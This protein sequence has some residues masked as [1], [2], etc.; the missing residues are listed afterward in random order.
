MLDILNRITQGEGKEEDLDV[1]EKMSDEVRTMSLCGLGQS[2][3]N[4]IRSTLR[5]FR[6]E[7]IAHIVDKKCPA[8]V[9]KALIK[10]S[11]LPDKCTGC[12]VC[13]RNCPVT[14]IYGEKKKVH[15]LEQDKCIKCGVC[16]SVC[17]FNAIKVE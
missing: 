11:I 10:F 5:Y 8:K 6:D 16:Y 9:C 3:P 13:A 1:L 17:K 7:Y 14:A 12:T 4:P 2:A 15:I